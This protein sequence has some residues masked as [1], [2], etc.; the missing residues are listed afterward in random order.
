MVPLQINLESG[1]LYQ[2]IGTINHVGNS[3]AS[4][5]Y[6]STVYDESQQKFYFMNDE[7]I[8]EL[9]TLNEMVFGQSLSET[10]YMIFY[11]RV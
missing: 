8:S 1:S 4:G 5:H 7:V 9:Q 11:R 2:I 10:I 3:S 6:T